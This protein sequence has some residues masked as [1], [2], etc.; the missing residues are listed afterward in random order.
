MIPIRLPA[1]PKAGL[2]PLLLVVAPPEGVEDE[3]DLDADADLLPL[4]LTEAEGILAAGGAV[5]WEGLAIVEV[6]VM[7]IPLG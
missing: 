6:L 2:A 5:I 7:V 3:P 1:T 4:P